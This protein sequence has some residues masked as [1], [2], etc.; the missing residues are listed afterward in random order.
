MQSRGNARREQRRQR[1]EELVGAYTE[2]GRALV[3]VQ[4]AIR[5][6]SYAARAASEGGSEQSAQVLRA[7]EKTDASRLMHGYQMLRLYGAPAEVLQAHTDF[8]RGLD[9]I[10]RKPSG[11]VSSDEGLAFVESL[12][13]QVARFYELAGQHARSVLSRG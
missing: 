10:V 13:V 12:G 3:E 8:D 6:A 4:R 11:W 1:Y 2:A 7:F 9:H 5:A